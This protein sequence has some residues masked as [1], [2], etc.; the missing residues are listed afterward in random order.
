MKK[1]KIEPVSFGVLGDAEYIKVTVSTFNAA[2]TECNLIYNYLDS[3]NTILYTS[4]ISLKED[5]FIN[6][7]SDNM[8]L[9]EFV[10]NKLN[11]TLI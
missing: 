3:K 4:T 7:G 9:V 5:D 10:A 2:D 1:F 11:L 6:W 8:Y